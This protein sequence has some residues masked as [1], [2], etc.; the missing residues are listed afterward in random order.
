MDSVFV[1]P[2]HKMSFIVLLHWKCRMYHLDTDP[3]SFPIPWIQVMSCVYSRAA[4]LKGQAAV[5]HLLV[6]WFANYPLGTRIC[7]FFSGKQSLPLPVHS[8]A[9]LYLLSFPHCLILHHRLPCIPSFLTLHS[10][11]PFPRIPGATLTS[12]CQP[13]LLLCP[14]FGSPFPREGEDRWER[15]PAQEM[16]YIGIS[17]HLTRQIFCA[18]VFS[19]SRVCHHWVKGN[20]KYFIW[21]PGRIKRGWRGKH[22]V[23]D[24]TF[25]LCPSSP[26]CSVGAFALPFSYQ[27]QGTGELLDGENSGWKRI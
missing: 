24:K 21:L 17:N 5:C 8:P 14:G 20:T 7:S 9:W 13:Q 4:P 26:C 19:N 22:M 1:W 15:D 16:P 25:H 3:C 6:Q 11:V 27:G 12:P 10:R 2:Q 18:Q 23:V